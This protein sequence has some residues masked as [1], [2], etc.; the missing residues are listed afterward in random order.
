MHPNCFKH[1]HIF[2]YIL[3]QVPLEVG[4]EVERGGGGECGVTNL[5]NIYEEEQEELEEDGSD[6]ESEAGPEA[7]SDEDDRIEE[8]AGKA[9]AEPVEEIKESPD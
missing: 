7:D 3:L 8:L 5:L 1:I 4:V 2:F 9:A 6:A